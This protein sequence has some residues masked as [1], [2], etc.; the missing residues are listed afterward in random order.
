MIQEEQKIKSND[1]RLAYL[2]T[3]YKTDLFRIQKMIGQ[4]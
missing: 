1:P 2:L 4:L 3:R